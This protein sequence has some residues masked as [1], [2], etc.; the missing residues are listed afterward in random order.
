MPISKAAYAVQESRAQEKVLKAEEALGLALERLQKAAEKQSEIDDKLAK[1]TADYAKANIMVATMTGTAQTHWVMVVEKLTKQMEAAQK[2]KMGAD[3]GVWSAEKSAN[4]ADS[5]VQTASGQL[6]ATQS[7]DPGALGVA[8]DAMGQFN[9]VVG[10]VTGSFTSLAGSV[11][12]YIEAFAPST[13]LVFNQYIKDLTAVIGMALEPVLTGLTEIVKE[14]GA[15]LLPI[16]EQMRPIIEQVTGAFVGVLVPIVQNVGAIFQALA[17]SLKFFADVIDVIAVLSRAQSAVVAGAIA[18]F[19]AFLDSIFS[20]KS[21]YTDFMDGFKSAIQMVISFLLRLVVT[22]A[23]LIGADS[24]IAGL[25][26]SLSGEG[27]AAKKPIE[28]MAAPTNVSTT[29]AVGLG[30]KVT[31][32]AFGAMGGATLTRKPEEYL[33]EL[34]V[35]LKGIAGSDMNWKKMLMDV[36]NDLVGKVL[37]GV[38]LNIYDPIVSNIK[39]IKES[40]EKFLGRGTP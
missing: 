38:K 3:T 1:V 28:G 14:V 10:L 40:V 11:T 4:K 27:I 24:F 5:G 37:A 22:I 25:I 33:A 34:L 9:A 12:G 39:S 32:M 18:H 16:A 30:Q 31:E 35:E 23:K 26:K 17:P 6:A 19:M 7:G 29:N 20:N 21:G 8:A 13:V 15:V 2:A 36:G